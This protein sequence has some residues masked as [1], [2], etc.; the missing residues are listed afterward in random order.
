MKCQSAQFY[1]CC[2]KNV[3]KEA[4]FFP[5]PLNFPFSGHSLLFY[6]GVEL[7]SNIVFVSGVWEL[8]SLIQRYLSVLFGVLFLI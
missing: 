7:I 2:Y 6:F 8:D 4:A 3:H 1:S 5:V